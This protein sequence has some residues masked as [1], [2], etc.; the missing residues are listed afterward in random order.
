LVKAVSANNIPPDLAA[1]LTEPDQQSMTAAVA[2]L[3]LAWAL[4]ASLVRAATAAVA[5]L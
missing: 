5:T 3:L 2:T 1:G 4:G